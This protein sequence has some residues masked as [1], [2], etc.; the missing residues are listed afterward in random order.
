MAI[1]K[2]K[3]DSN[4]LKLNS[5]KL[6]H[7][8]PNLF[9]QLMDD[10][11]SQDEHSCISEC[12]DTQ[13][14]KIFDIL[15]IHRLESFLVCCFT[16]LLLAVT[17][18]L[19]IMPLQ[20]IFASEKRLT[21]FI[22]VS[23]MCLSSYLLVQITNPSKIYHTL[24]GQS[25]F[26]LYMIKAVN[27]ILDLLLKGYG[28]GVVDNFARAQIRANRF[29]L[30]TATLGLTIYTTMHS[31]ILCLEMFTLHVV[32]TSSPDSILSFLFYNNFTE[33]KITVFKKCDA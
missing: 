13:Y 30:F 12:E 31:F 29:D 1:R 5:L 23:V 15:K 32:L 24:R 3:S 8:Q 11:F 28:R 16:F 25:I 26:K 27:E 4:I 2:C 33:V 17:H 6:P 22:R 19:L 20:V 9:Q 21:R 14:N 10:V 7:Q 18:N